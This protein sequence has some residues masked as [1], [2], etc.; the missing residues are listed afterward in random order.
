VFLL[1]LTARAVHSVLRN[2]YLSVDEP[3]RGSTPARAMDGA[4]PEL[5][6]DGVLREKRHLHGTAGA[7]NAQFILND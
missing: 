1:A 7:D 3:L 5:R 2:W 6:Q 4:A